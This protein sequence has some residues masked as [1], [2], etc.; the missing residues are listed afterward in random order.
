MPVGSRYST[1]ELAKPKMT[2]APRMWPKL[3]TPNT[4][5]RLI[6]PNIGGDGIAGPTLG[7]WIEYLPMAMA[8]I[9]QIIITMPTFGLQETEAEV[10]TAASKME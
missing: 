3:V 4:A 8:K 1:P 5:P 6:P 7:C 9:L 2:P 10:D